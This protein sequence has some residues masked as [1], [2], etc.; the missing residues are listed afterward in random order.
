[1]NEWRALLRVEAKL[2]FREPISWL[3]AVALPS[4]ILLIFG[5]VFPPGAPDPDL[6]GLRFLDVFVPS[7]VVIS[8]GTLGIQTLPIRL[9]T[10]RERGFLR[11]LSTT[12]AHPLRVLVAQ[13]VTYLV[14]AVV[15]LALLLVV[16]RIAF[17]IELPRDMAGFVLAF[18]A[19]TSSMFAIGLVLAALAPSARVATS[20]AIPMF[21][22]VM[23]LGGVYVPRV[24]LPEALRRIGEF[25]PPG[26]Q[27]LQDAWQGIPPATLPL[28]A[29]AV[30]TVVAGAVAVRLF[31]WE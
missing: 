31:R 20:V 24:A 16:A 29:M 6:G 8:L 10:Y 12:P 4:A 3:A 30:F 19:G 25:A 22:G 28:V 9:A 15:A 17:G 7:L 18:A 11:R 2:L 23:F 14:T 26:V 13:L 5:T 1:M 27:S 21:F